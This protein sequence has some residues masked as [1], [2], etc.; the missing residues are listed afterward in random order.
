MLPLLRLVVERR[1]GWRGLAFVWLE[2]RSGLLLVDPCCSSPSRLPFPFSSSPLSTIRFFAIVSLSSLEAPEDA[3]RKDCI[4]ASLSS[5][6]MSS[7][8]SC[9]TL[10][11]GALN[12]ARRFRRPE[13]FFELN[14][15][16]VACIV[17]DG[18]YGTTCVWSKAK[19]CCAVQVGSRGGCGT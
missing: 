5:S 7:G 10:T 4:R 17:R 1:M 6:S 13:V 3:D 12:F 19:M 8:E 9:M 14:R 16:E 11:S 18:G 15:D 2:N